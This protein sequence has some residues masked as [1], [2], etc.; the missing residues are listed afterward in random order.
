MIYIL[1]QSLQ[2]L[3]T[4]YDQQ[5]HV[6]PRFV[7]I[8]DE[9]ALAF[10]DAS[11]FIDELVDKGLVSDSQKTELEHM[12]VLLDQMS[13]EKNLWTLKALE[14]SLPWE[15]VRILAKDILQTFHQTVQEPHLFWIQYIPGE[16][17]DGSL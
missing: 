15:N 14:M 12:D 2:L 3:A 8:P 1:L 10:D 7:H 9:V 17:L 4:P 11:I 16:K 6:L 13:K 5:L